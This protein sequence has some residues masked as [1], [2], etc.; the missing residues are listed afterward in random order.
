MRWLLI[1][2]IIAK[3]TTLT[4]TLSRQRERELKSQHCLSYWLPLPPCGRVGV[5][6]AQ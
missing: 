5:R 4:L 2:V 1:V 6:V 3:S